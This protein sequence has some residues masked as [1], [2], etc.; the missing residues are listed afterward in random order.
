MFTVGCGKKKD[1]DSGTTVQTVTVITTEGTT[2]KTSDTTAESTTE[3]TTENTT[4]KTTASTESPTEATTEVTNESTSEEATE[5]TTEATSATTEE[6]INE[7]EDYPAED[8]VYTSKDDVAL[9]LYIYGKLP[10]NFIT[11]KQAQKLGWSG[12]SLEDYAPGKCIGGDRFGNYEHILPDGNYYECDIDTLGKKSRGA[13]RIV[14]SKD[15]R[16]YY[17]EDHYE[18][19]TLL[20]GEE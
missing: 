12:G 8:G 20:Y 14:Y 7:T 2:E 18:S 6:D 9:Y 11:K 15:G 1:K 17:T 19:F 5:L 16:I 13:K 4:E 10:Q 3:V